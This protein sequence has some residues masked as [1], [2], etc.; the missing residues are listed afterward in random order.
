MK[1]ILEQ[2]NLR[3]TNGWRMALWAMVALG[4]AMFIAGLV[5][6]AAQR[7]W[8]AFLINTTYWG[9][10]A[11]AGVMLSVIWQITDA[12]WGRPFKRLSEGYASFLPVSLV[13]F[14]LLYF[15]AGHLYEWVHHPM[16][17][18]EAYLNM[19]FFVI[20]NTLGL[21]V[22]IWLTMV[23]VRNSL[24]PDMAA[25]RKL[26]AGFGGT[27]GDRLLNGYGD[28][29]VEV[30]RLELKARKL[31]PALGV[32]Y[33]VVMSLVAFDFVMSLDQLWFSTLF[34]VF[35]F[36]GNLYTALALMLIIVTFTRNRPV[37][38]EFMSINRFN[39]LAKL[40]FA[41]AMLYT[42]MAFSQFLVIWYS[43][44]PE[45]APFLVERA[46]A[47]TPW[48]PL[49]WILV[50]LLFV[51]PFLTLATR[52]ICR[53][54]K[55]AAGIAFVLMIGQWWAHYLLIVPSVQGS[56][57]EPHFVF[58]LHEILLTAGFG[59]GFF[60]CFFWFMGK[61]PLLPISD[62]RLSKTWHG[63]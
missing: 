18:K 13:M 16:H 60:L 49:F 8:Q 6:G 25:A 46:I 31:A 30:D 38:S 7:T 20:R 36:I 45:E 62:K 43:N 61:V 53:I 23:Y 44:L 37:I 59:A 26:V 10:M 40:T 21:A 19:P 57:G 9:G 2:S 32:L 17:V 27:F 56:H 28:H 58:G 15:G 41:I 50:V 14:I 39:D 1:E 35:F 29:K 52:T 55:L 22:L 3:L 5:S 4:V 12:R 47:D 63:H 24:A 54:P 51:L 33:A 34:G 48:R 11:Q 42:Y